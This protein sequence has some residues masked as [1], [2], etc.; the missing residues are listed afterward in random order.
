M[1]VSSQS[2]VNYVN[3]RVKITGLQGPGT[4]AR[5]VNEEKLVTHLC[6]RIKV[7]FFIRSMPRCKWFCK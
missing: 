5:P 4:A 2:C 7:Q 6:Y 1:Y 3:V